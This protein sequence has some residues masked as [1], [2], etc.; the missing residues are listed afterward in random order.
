MW[1]NVI[2]HYENK[3]FLVCLEDIL[4]IL[5]STLLSTQEKTKKVNKKTRNVNREFQLRENSN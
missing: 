3:S 4:E 2:L 5:A 1:K